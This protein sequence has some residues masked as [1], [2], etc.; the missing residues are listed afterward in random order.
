MFSKYSQQKI[1]SMTP[2]D[3]IVSSPTEVLLDPQSGSESEY[4]DEGDAK[5]HVTSAQKELQ[6]DLPYDG[7]LLS[8]VGYVD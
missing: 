2:P 8:D 7:D 1:P 3:R 5:Y 4:S 6:R